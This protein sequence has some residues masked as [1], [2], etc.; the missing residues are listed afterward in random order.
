MTKKRVQLKPEDLKLKG[1]VWKW[2][3]PGVLV[4]IQAL[5]FTLPLLTDF[6]QKLTL[7]LFYGSLSIHLLVLLQYNHQIDL[8]F[9]L[10]TKFVLN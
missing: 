2:C 3:Q 9:Q 4:P 6:V 10:R 8:L 5:S 7:G 1:K